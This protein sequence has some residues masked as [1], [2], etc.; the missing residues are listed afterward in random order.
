[1][2]AQFIHLLI[3]TT[4]FFALFHFSCHFHYVL[5]LFSSLSLALSP[6]IPLVMFLFQVLGNFLNSRHFCG[7]GY[8]PFFP[9]HIQLSLASTLILR[10]QTHTLWATENHSAPFFNYCWKS[11]HLDW[12]TGAQLISHR[13]SAIWYWQTGY[14]GRELLWTHMSNVSFQLEYRPD[15][16]FLSCVCCYSQW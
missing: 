1:M 9:L 14:S 13:I 12:D 4:L 6:A 3:I 7:S 11:R 5:F 2:Q 16:L 10:W 15:N 8:R